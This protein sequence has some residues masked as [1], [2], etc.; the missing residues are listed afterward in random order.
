MKDLLFAISLAIGVSACS[1]S[2]K[3]D[4]LTMIIGTY[5]HAGSEGIYTYKFD[6]ENGTAKSLEVI[7]MENPSYLTLSA[8]QQ[9]MYVVSE[10]HDETASVSAFKFD[11]ESGKAELMN[12]QLTYGEDPCY[13]ATNGKIVTTA[14][15]SG[16][17]MS[18]FP[19]HYDGSLEPVDTIFC[20]NIGGPDMSRQE[21]PHV[22]CTVF[23]PDGKQLLA[24]D[25]SADRILHF[26]VESA[27]SKPH[28][29]LENTPITADSG[30]RHIIFSHD[31]KYVYIISELSEAVTVCSYNEGNMQ[32]IQTIETHPQ[33]DRH[34]ADIHLSPDGK[35]LYA[36]VRNKEDGLAIF[37]VDMV[38]GL[39]EKVGY[40]PTGKHPRNFNI[41]PN[42]KYILVADMND[43]KIEIFERDLQ[44]GLLTNTQRDIQLS[45]PVCIVFAK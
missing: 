22:H 17:S 44:T 24:T 5:T 30:P 14:N 18:V 26:D 27:S 6:Q 35:F 12:S 2:P 45:M 23:S 34:A 20:G 29:K 8:N 7:P 19:L 21:T 28:L 40:Q 15:Y 32:V 3:S 25:F 10:Q 37:K 31:G 11:K 16:G 39:L 13:V 1:T 33:A 36:S 43:N 4:E 41:T 38:T 9:V 42:G